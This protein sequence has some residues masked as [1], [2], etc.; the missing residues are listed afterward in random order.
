MYAILLW[1]F[2]LRRGWWSDRCDVGGYKARGR[3]EGVGGGGYRGT[4]SSRGMVCVW[5]GGEGGHSGKW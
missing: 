3:Q 4:G 2:A 1:L 5:G